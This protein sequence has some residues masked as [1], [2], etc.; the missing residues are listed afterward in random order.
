MR[1]YFEAIWYQNGNVW[2][3]SAETQII[4]NSTKD[5]IFEII[6]DSYN[7]GKEIELWHSNIL[8]VFK[9][10]N[11]FSLDVITN[12]KLHI[13]CFSTESMDTFPLKML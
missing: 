3:A 7:L 6:S 11:L 10:E 2:H 13:K 12:D 1:K 9:D 8:L 5:G 4:M